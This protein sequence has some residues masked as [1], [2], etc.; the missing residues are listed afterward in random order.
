MI[1]FSSVSG[2]TGGEAGEGFEHRQVAYRARVHAGLDACLP[3]AEVNPRQLHTAMRDAVMSGGKRLRPLLCY[4][5]AEA[6]GVAPEAVDAAAIAVELIHCYSLVHDDLPCM[7]DDEF[8]RGRPA[9]HRLHGEDTALLVGDAL[10]TLAWEVLAGHP[11]LS[12]RERARAALAKLFAEC[13]GST[14]MAGGQQLDLYGGPE[15]DQAE[16]EHAFR[17]KTGALFRAAALGPVCVKPQT[18]FAHRH[19]LE[20]FA[21]LLGL[22][23]QIRDD[24]KDRRTDTPANAGARSSRLPSFVERFGE[25]AARDRIEELIADMQAVSATFGP[26]GGGLRWMTDLVGGA[27]PARRPPL[28]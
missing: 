4:A 20:Q 27:L 21:D 17:T 26:S 10:Q 19:A 2:A 9:V 24:L 25:T 23:F 13:A 11:S 14:G 8:R 3:A 1:D 22:A 16:L 6:S 15:P 7:D 18:P 12:G 5:A 28:Q